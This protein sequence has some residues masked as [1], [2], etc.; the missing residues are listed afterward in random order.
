[1]HMQPNSIFDMLTKPILVL[2]A[3]MFA[4]IWL[5]NVIA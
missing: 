3:I 4:L 1:M 2:V 5:A